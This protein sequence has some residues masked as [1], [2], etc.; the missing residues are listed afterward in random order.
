M[1]PEAEAKQLKST[2]LIVNTL[3][4]RRSQGIEFKNLQ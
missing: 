3:A 2:V 4:A 1:N